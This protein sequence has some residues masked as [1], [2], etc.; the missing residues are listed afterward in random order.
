M[1]GRKHL[2]AVLV[3]PEATLP[4]SKPTLLHGKVVV[5][6]GEVLPPVAIEVVSNHALSGPCCEAGSREVMGLQIT[7][8]SATGKGS[9]WVEGGWYTA[10]S[11]VDAVVEDKDNEQLSV[12]GFG[13]VYLDADDEY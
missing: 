3:V 2:D 4:S 11:V 12:V 8:V 13:S 10:L 5:R 1:L 7:H 9:N 6:R